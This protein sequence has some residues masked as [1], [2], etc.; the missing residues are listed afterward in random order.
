MLRVNPLGYDLCT[1]K[2]GIICR[3]NSKGVVR[4]RVQKVGQG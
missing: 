3:W 1:R 4:D 2:P